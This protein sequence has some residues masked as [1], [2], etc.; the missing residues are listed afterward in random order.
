MCVIELNSEALK[1]SSKYM[2]SISNNNVLDP[3]NR[4][5]QLELELTYL[6][7]LVKVNTILARINEPPIGKDT[8]VYSRVVGDSIQLIAERD[9]FAE[10]E[11]FVDYGS[12]FD[13]S[14]YMDNKEALLNQE[15][16]KLELERLRKES[17]R[18]QSIV[19]DPDS[20]DIADQDTSRRGGFLDKLVKSEDNSKAAGILSPEDAARQFSE[21]GTDMF[22]S[23][24]DKDIIEGL[25]G[26]GTISENLKEN[27]ATSPSNKNEKAIEEYFKQSE[28]DFRIDDDDDDDDISSFDF[29]ANLSEAATIFGDVT[30][31]IAT[32]ESFDSKA[33][34]VLV[35]PQETLLSPEEAMS[36]QNSI[37]NMTE[38]QIVKVFANLKNTLNNQMAVEL[39]EAI[40]K[41]KLPIKS[42]KKFPKV[43]P[44]NQNLKKDYEKEFEDFE[45][46][47]EKMYEDPLAVWDKLLNNA[48]DYLSDQDMEEIARLQEILDKNK[49]L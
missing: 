16:E 42:S 38:E 17:G 10:E 31:N 24:E 11:L 45:K 36:L 49:K 34:D 20:A 35:K 14:D 33:N 29:D 19:A 13:R 1:A 22:A 12:K 44:I 9:I 30:K 25:T 3:T 21:I 6:G 40:E 48:D 15:K 39:N 37:D 47:L 43:E 5:G 2:W 27:R 7:G 23:S 26:K 41:R 46:E 28:D 4:Q 18:F 32:I 8:N